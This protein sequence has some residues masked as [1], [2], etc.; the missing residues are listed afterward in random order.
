MIAVIFMHMAI[1][2]QYENGDNPR[3]TPT[4]LKERAERVNLLLYEEFCGNSN[5]NHQSIQYAD[6]RGRFALPFDEPSGGANLP[7]DPRS[8]DARLDP[9]TGSLPQ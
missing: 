3:S 6:R 8:P 9:F 1:S 2:Y 5:V 4:F 7:G